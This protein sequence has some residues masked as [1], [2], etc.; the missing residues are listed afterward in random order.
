[1]QMD[2]FI[3]SR[4]RT[5]GRRQMLDRISRI[6]GYDQSTTIIAAL[7]APLHAGSHDLVKASIDITPIRRHKHSD[8]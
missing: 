4:Q 8:E 2:F 7:I 5:E 3:D 1:M 6:C